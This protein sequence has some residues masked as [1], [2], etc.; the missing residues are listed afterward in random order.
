MIIYKPSFKR[1]NNLKI[2]N[3]NGVEYVLPEAAA[4]A[5]GCAERTI[6]HLINEGRLK[7]NKD[8]FN[9][10]TLQFWLIER[11]SVKQFIE[12]YLE[13]HPKSK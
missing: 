12:K 9:K 4:H 11:D 6:R 7:G 5:I 1:F 3:I 2:Y 10:K 13:E 8:I